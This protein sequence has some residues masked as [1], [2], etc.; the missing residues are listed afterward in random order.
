[1]WQNVLPLQA[2]P[3]VSCG[4]R[5]SPL[6]RIQRLRRVLEHP[7]VHVHPVQAGLCQP[8]GHLRPVPEHQRHIPGRNHRHTVRSGQLSSAVR[9]EFHQKVVPPKR[10]SAPGWE[11]LG[12]LGGVP[13]AHGRA[14]RGPELCRSWHNRL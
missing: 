9:A 1:M 5:V 11:S 3:A 7:D 6:D 4:G 13:A 10:G 12:P 2:N 8:G 14:G